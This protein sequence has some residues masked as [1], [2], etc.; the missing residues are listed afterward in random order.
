[1]PVSTTATL[2]SAPVFI[3]FSALIRSIPVGSV[4]LFFACGAGLAVEEVDLGVAVGLEMRVG[5]DLVVLGFLVVLLIFTILSSTT[6]ATRG[7]LRTLAKEAVD[8]RAAIP[9]KTLLYGRGVSN[10]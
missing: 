4:C 1:M 3:F 10:K 2:I 6:Y 5:V 9:L 8:I 7:S